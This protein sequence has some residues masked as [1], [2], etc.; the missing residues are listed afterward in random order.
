MGMEGADDS[1]ICWVSAANVSD[2]NEEQASVSPT[3]GLSGYGIE[4]IP[5]RISTDRSVGGV[6]VDT[7]S[8]TDVSFDQLLE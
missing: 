3:A 7:S 2:I 6:I 5:D 1:D 4:A 8:G